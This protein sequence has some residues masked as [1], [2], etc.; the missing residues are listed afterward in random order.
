M[1]TSTQE[2]PFIGSLTLSGPKKFKQIILEELDI[3]DSN[4]NWVVKLPNDFEVSPNSNV[5][6]FD[7]LMF[8]NPLTIYYKSDKIITTWKNKIKYI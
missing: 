2:Y 3:F 6:Y 5:I 8:D 4:T 1:Y 7:E